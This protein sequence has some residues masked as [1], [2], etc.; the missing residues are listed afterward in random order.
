MFY[1]ISTLA[2]SLYMERTHGKVQFSTLLCIYTYTTENN[3]VQDRVLREDMK[4][5]TV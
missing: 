1:L 3:D 5:I 4:K 2:V